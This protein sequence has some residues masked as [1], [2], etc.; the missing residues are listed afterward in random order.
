MPVAKGPAGALK[1]PVAIIDLGSNAVRFVIYDALDRAPVKIHNERVQCHLGKNMAKTGYLNPDGVALAFEALGRFAGLIAAMNIRHVHAVA[2]AAMRDAIDGQDFIK[3]VKAAFGLS[4]RVIGGEEE[5]RLSA[6]GV[7]MNGLGVEASGHSGIIGDYGGGSLELIVVEK[8]SVRHKVSFPMGAHRLQVIEGTPARIRAV[9]AML[10]TAPFL[11]QSTGMDFYAMGG[12]WRSIGKAHLG[13]TKHPLPVLDHYAVE[14]GQAAA[15][16]EMISKQSM[17]QLKKKFG[18]V[19][20]RLH[21]MGVAALAMYRV[22]RVLKP[23]RLVFSGTGLR[24]GLMYD[25]LSPARK[26]QDALLEGS[27]KIALHAG[28]FSDLKPYAALEKFIVPLFSKEGRD[29]QRLAA[30]ACRLSDICWFEHEDVQAS[31]A[32]SRALTAP[33]YGVSHSGRAFLGIALALRYGEDAKAASLTALHG[34]LDGLDTPAVTAGRALHLAH[35]LTGGDLLLLSK[36]SLK[37][38][39]KTLTLHL[40]GQARALRAENVD[41]ALAALAEGMGRA[42]KIS[43]EG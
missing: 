9:D 28:R 24:E 3:S 19:E 18:M 40:A 38:T 21:D 34:V 26:K 30:A 41:K 29:V 1:N 25:R 16:A 13:V 10:K 32:L 17:A 2:T 37:A 22:F 42:A 35:L 20:K 8:G 7:L 33:L 12:A 5:A 4:I 31:Y 27:G 11:K 36:A 14:G 43:M 39:P 6:H 23:A 15:F